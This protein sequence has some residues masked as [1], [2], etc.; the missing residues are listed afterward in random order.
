MIKSLYNSWNFCFICSL[1]LLFRFDNK[2]VRKLGIFQL[3]HIFRRSIY[4][5]PWGSKHSY[6]PSEIFRENN[7]SLS[8]STGSQEDMT[9]YEPLFHLSFSLL[10]RRRWPL[11]LVHR[12][13]IVWEHLGDSTQV[14]FRIDVNKIDVKD[15][16]Q[17]FIK[18]FRQL[19]TSC[20]FMAPTS[21][22]LPLSWSLLSWCHCLIFSISK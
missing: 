2:R 9:K 20:Q 15:P 19:S 11:P 14:S 21:A 1:W 8:L 22:P 10:F 5:Q 17:E 16:I 4:Q 13:D 18:S 3:G 7:L 12:L 6:L